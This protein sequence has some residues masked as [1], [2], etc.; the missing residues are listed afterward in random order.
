MG[1]DL[2]EPEALYFSQWKAVAFRLPHTQPEAL[3]WWD[4]P[5]SF[6][7]LCTHDILPHTDASGMRDFQTMRQDKTLALA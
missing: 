7:R 5:P 4:S 2:S 6:H 1:S 3:G